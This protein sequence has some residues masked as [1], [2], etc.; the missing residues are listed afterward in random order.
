MKGLP[1]PFGLINKTPAY[2]TTGP[3]SDN[4]VSSDTCL[5][6]SPG[7]AF[8]GRWIKELCASHDDGF[9]NGMYLLAHMK[10]ISLYLCDQHIFLL[11]IHLYLAD[12]LP[13]VLRF[14]MEKLWEKRATS[15]GLTALIFANPGW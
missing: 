10:Y 7:V 11:A 5:S 9:L 3:C 8:F 6:C 2:L 15:A 14:R 4:V 12:A 1:K 13:K